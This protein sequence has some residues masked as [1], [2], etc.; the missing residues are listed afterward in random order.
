M[1]SQRALFVLGLICLCAAWPALGQNDHLLIT[2]FVVTPTNGEFI[3]IFNPTSANV[4]LSHYYLTDDNASNNNDYVKVVNGA[5]ALTLAA[6]DF[7]VKFPDGAS[8]A[9]GEAQTIAFSD[10][11]FARVY[12]KSASYE[13][14][15]SNIGVTDMTAIVVR[16]N[17]SLTNAAEVIVLFRWDGQADLVQDADYVVWGTGNLSV[18]VDKTGSSIDGPDADSDSSAYQNDTPIGNQAVVN[19]DDGGDSQP[20]SI[21]ASAARNAFEA[22]ETLTGG[23]GI[24][25]HDETSENL[26]FAG[27]SWI[28]NAAPTPGSV[29]EALKRQP[30]ANFVA[31]LSGAQEVPPINTPAGGQ[32]TATLTEDQLVITG[33]FNNLSS[34]FNAAVRG[35]AHLHLAPA[36]RNGEVQIELTA[37]VNADQ[38][39]GTFEAANNTFTLSNDLVAALNDR[40]LYANIHTQTHPGGEIRGQVLP[41]NDSFFTAV[42]SAG[43]EIQP[44]ASAARG[45]VIAELSGTRITLTGSFSDLTSEFNPNIRG[46]AHLH[47]A[48]ASQNGSIQIELAAVLEADARGGVFEAARNTF[49]LTTDQVTALRTGGMYA[50]VHTQ[51]LGSGETRGQL[52]SDPNRFPNATTITSPASGSTVVIEGSGENLLQ[53]TWNTSTDPDNNLVVYLWQLAA[54]RQFNT[55]LINRNTNTEASFSADAAEVDSI[56]TGMGLAAGDTITLYHRA[57]TSDGSLQSPGAIDS[58]NVTLRG[59]SAVEERGDSLPVEF[60]LHGN[61]PNPCNPSTLIRYDLPRAAHV[62]LVIY[63]VLGKNVRTLVDAKQAPGFKHVTWDGANDKGERVTSGVYLYRIETDGFTAERKLTLLR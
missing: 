35:G 34:G 37:T 39:G 10:T 31:T 5:A 2:E 47:V 20:H 23:N 54:D 57:V 53:A 4:D 19:A 61:Y 28:L 33:A 50:N 16:T 27:G 48:P 49:T 43:N 29:P 38:R 9:P 36:G 42:L 7:L 32:L 17:A 13:I 56:L 8:I 21:G 6:A 24:T 51:T 26:S 58:I 12:G 18:A 1:Q 63:S 25:G 60:A 14:N 55:L 15:S 40:K 59:M 22:G 44:V 11:A 45:A 62:K 41:E 46:G 52:L 30:V 3:E